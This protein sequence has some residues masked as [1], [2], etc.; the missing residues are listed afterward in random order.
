MNLVK[1]IS[2]EIDNLNRRVVKFLRMGKSDVQTSIEAL[3]Y[4][5]DSNPIKDMVAVYAP[6]GEKG[7]TVIIG[8]LNKNQI[9]DIGE[10]RTYSTNEDGEEQFYTWLKNDGTLELGGDGKNVA[11][12]QE[13]ET[14]FNELRDDFNNFVNTVY[15]VHVHSGV[16]SGFA[17]TAVTP[18]IGTPS[19]ADI[20]GAKI[21]E[22]KCL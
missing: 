4:G 19:T 5:I 9:A 3:P 13:L 10:V 17:S 8:Y 22:I 1:V 11:R 12:Y 16:L 15:N 7:K 14:A 18:S 20:T 6:T 2:T 21:D